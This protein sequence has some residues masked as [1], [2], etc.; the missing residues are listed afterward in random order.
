VVAWQWGRRGGFSLETLH[1]SAVPLLL[2][3][4]PGKQSNHF[5]DSLWGLHGN[6]LCALIN[7]GNRH[8][9]A[10]WKSQSR[11]HAML[12]YF[13]LLFFDD[14]GGSLLFGFQNSEFNKSYY[15]LILYGK[16]IQLR[17]YL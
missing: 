12:G 16:Q 10:L 7:T 3:L 9:M 11:N 17:R 2:R 15:G 14:H 5:F 6:D 1:E 13:A 8:E 4:R